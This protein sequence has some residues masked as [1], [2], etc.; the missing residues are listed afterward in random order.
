M[1]PDLSSAIER[2]ECTFHEMEMVPPHEVALLAEYAQKEAL[3]SDLNEIADAAA[4]VT[5]AVRKSRI[6]LHSSM[7]IMSDAISHATSVRLAA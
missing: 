3:A 4:M 1:K 7:R 6:S 5:A 2:I